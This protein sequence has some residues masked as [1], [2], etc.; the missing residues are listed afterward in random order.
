MEEPEDSCHFPLQGGI[1][2]NGS[3]SISLDA[4]G[5]HDLEEEK[6]KSHMREPEMIRMRGLTQSSPTLTPQLQ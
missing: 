3:I 2:V 6:D 5:A 4:A 1:T